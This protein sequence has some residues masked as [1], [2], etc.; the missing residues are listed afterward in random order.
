MIA[1]STAREAD[2]LED[3]SERLR[4]ES[5]MDAMT[6]LPNRRRFDRELN[7]RCAAS[8]GP[9]ALIM[10]DI[11]RFKS[12]NDTHGHDAGDAILIAVGTEV[13][14]VAS[15]HETPAIACRLGGEEF[16]VL[17][18]GGDLLTAAR[19]ADRIRQAVAR[20]RTP[21]PTGGELPVTLSAGVCMGDGGHKPGDV[22]KLADRALYAAKE[23]GRDTV[24]AF[25][26]AA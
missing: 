10:V 9:F 26:A 15:R 25:R 19:L 1:L 22:Y 16:G 8:T 18:D 7:E 6:G 12:V 4:V 20:L 21:L 24:R 13:A 23:G 3:E 17:L 11:D 5:E 2:Q 14:A